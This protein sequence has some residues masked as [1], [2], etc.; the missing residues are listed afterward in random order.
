[1]DSS[2]SVKGWT[3]NAS[4]TDRMKLSSLVTS[5]RP[6]SDFWNAWEH[7]LEIW[8][9]V[10]FQSR[11][12][13]WFPQQ[14]TLRYDTAAVGLVEAEGRTLV[15]DDRGDVCDGEHGLTKVES[16]AAGRRSDRKVGQASAM[17]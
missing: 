14:V 3:P 11:P 7:T 12:G 2:A 13:R 1:M 6:I 10:S 5:L 9:S 17:H 15:M 4:R 16:S 8:K